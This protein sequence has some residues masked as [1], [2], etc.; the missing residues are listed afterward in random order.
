M[1]QFLALIRRVT[2]SFSDDDFAPL[3]EPEAERARQL[4]TQ[5]IFRAMWGRQDVPGGVTL[6]GAET[7]EGPGPGH[8]NRG[9]DA[10]RGGGFSELAPAQSEGDARDRADRDRPLPRL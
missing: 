9:G 4:Y 3:M 6:I 5:G 7:Q 10:S 1:A 2:E 8:A